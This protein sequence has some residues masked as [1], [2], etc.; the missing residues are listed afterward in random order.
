MYILILSLHFPFQIHSPPFSALFPAPG[1]W[2]YTVIQLGPL[3]KDIQ[4]VSQWEAPVGDQRVGRVSG[5]PPH[6]WSCPHC[7]A[8]PGFSSRGSSLS[9]LGPEVV[10]SSHWWQS[11]GASVSF[12]GSLNLLILLTTGH[13]LNLLPA[14]TMTY[15]N[16][17]DRQTHKCTGLDFHKCEQV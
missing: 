6:G 11:L 16:S 5:I 9:T 2:L 10:A 8:F 17:F 13:L 12:V 4:L 1:G 7:T 3:P 15:T 14:R